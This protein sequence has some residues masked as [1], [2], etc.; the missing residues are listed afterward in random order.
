M[1]GRWV[2]PM[3]RMSVEEMVD[4]R[5]VLMADPRAVLSVV[6]WAH[7]MAYPTVVWTVGHWVGQSAVQ[8]ADL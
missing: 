6:H 1:V 5:A 4:L 8:T 3:A 2:V 7:Q